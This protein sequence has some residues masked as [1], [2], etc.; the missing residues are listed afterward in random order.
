[1]LGP[2]NVGLLDVFCGYPPTFVSKN[3]GYKLSIVAISHIHFVV[4]AGNW[5][6]LFNG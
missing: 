4:A 2:N 5:V 6:G 3:A 1:M